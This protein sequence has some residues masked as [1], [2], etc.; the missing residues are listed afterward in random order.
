M[1]RFI[2]NP[3]GKAEGDCLGFP[4]NTELVNIHGCAIHFWLGDAAASK[5]RLSR[6][7]RAARNERDIVR[8]TYSN[9]EPEGYWAHQDIKRSST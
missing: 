3:G 2:V 7:E 4:Y 5:D 8:L 1:I 6:L 9:G